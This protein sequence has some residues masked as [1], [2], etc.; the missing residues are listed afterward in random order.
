MLTDLH[1]DV[2]TVST[3]SLQP[4]PDN[5]K[6]HPPEQIEKLAES[7]EEYGFTQPIVVNDDQEIIIGHGRLEAAKQ[8]GMDEVPV[9]ERGDLTEEEERALRLA[10][11]RLNEAPW[12]DELLAQEFERVDDDA[13]HGFNDDEVSEIVD[14][15]NNITEDEFD[16]AEHVDDDTQVEHGE[17]WK[18]GDHYLMCGDATRKKDVNKL[19]DTDPSTDAVDMVFTDPPYNVQLDYNDYEDDKQDDEYLTIV[20]DFVNQIKR[21]TAP[22]APVYIMCAEKYIP[23]I[24]GIMKE[25]LHFSE[26]LILFWLKE[27]ATLGNADYQY[28]YETVLYGW[29]PDGSH[30]F[31]GSN[32]ELAARQVARD[33]GE[34]N[35]PHGAQRP[36]KLVADYITN[37]SQRGESVLDLFGGSGTT[38]I[39]A[40]QTDR[41][42]FMMEMDLVYCDVIIERWEQ[43]TDREAEQV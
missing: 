1:S 9:I 28:N 32:M 4:Y 22:G 25:T 14:E 18:L 36:V 15:F 37:S 7:I 40:E 23:E 19:L 21:V 6:E 31:Y 3:D 39:A 11:N 29:N 20:Q 8:L 35:T 41:Q 38:L 12:D 10:D 30:N 13:F 2:D 27:T 42:C 26:V 43:H 34:D 5:P 17:V 24:T 16:T 33:R